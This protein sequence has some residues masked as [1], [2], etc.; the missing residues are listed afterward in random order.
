M[1]IKKIDC[2][3]FSL[4]I[5]SLLVFVNVIFQQSAVAD[6]DYAGIDVCRPVTKKTMI[7]I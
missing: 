5:F 6:D 4:F 1:K 3:L 2:W 7:I